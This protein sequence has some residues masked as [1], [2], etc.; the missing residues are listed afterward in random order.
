MDLQLQKQHKTL[1][2]AM[3]ESHT[4]TQ[5]PFLAADL[6]KLS[7]PPLASPNSGSGAGGPT[8]H[9]GK[10]SRPADSAAGGSSTAASP[11]SASSNLATIT[12]APHPDPTTYFQD[13]LH[14]REPIWEMKGVTVAELGPLGTEA[15]F[16]DTL[17]DA[18]CEFR[19][20]ASATGIDVFLC[21]GATVSQG[22]AMA[23][24]KRANLEWNGMEYLLSSSGTLCGATFFW[25]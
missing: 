5:F 6:K 23:L 18:D 13:M 7:Q 22:L 3:T 2:M 21:P 19:E 14:G 8:T 15:S 11:P 12:V 20:T 4:S 10:S 25:D 24:A 9:N 16:D 17:D 1:G